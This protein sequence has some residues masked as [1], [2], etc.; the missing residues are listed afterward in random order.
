[1]F[2]IRLRPGVDKHFFSQLKAKCNR[3]KEYCKTWDKQLHDELIPFFETIETFS[4]MKE[5]TYQLEEILDGPAGRLQWCSPPNSSA[6]KQQRLEPLRVELT[7][8]IRRL[9]ELLMTAP[10]VKQLQDVQ[11]DLNRCFLQA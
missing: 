10:S 9:S 6:L 3:V 7:A 2:S 5:L 4:R 8:T 1:M 11:D